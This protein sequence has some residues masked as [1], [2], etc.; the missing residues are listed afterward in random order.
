MAERKTIDR[1]TILGLTAAATGTLLLSG[2]DLGEIDWDA[3]KPELPPQKPVTWNENPILERKKISLNPKDQQVVDKYRLLLEE[4]LGRYASEQMLRQGVALATQIDPLLIYQRI[5][6]GS[7][8]ILFGE[9]GIPGYITPRYN[10]KLEANSAIFAYGLIGNP[11]IPFIENIPVNELWNVASKYYDIPSGAVR[12][13]PSHESNPPISNIQA[14]IDNF[15]GTTTKY[16]MSLD[17]RAVSSLHLTFV[18]R[19]EL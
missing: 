6:A 16:F 15:K 10:A 11:R 7:E 2:C 19:R 8:P 9:E 14:S 5:E 4:I 12:R 17:T 3:G 18:P 1:R 13:G